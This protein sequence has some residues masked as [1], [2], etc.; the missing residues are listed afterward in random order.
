LAHC[1]SRKLFAALPTRICR[2][3][4]KDT[5]GYSA[6]GKYLH[7]QDGWLEM[8]TFNMAETGYMEN[9][10]SYLLA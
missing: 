5:V 8:A 2:K 9:G 4:C 6:A 10:W 3:C 7:L 1:S